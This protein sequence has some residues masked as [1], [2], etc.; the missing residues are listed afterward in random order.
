MTAPVN[1]SPAPYPSPDLPRWHA[2]LKP[3]ATWVKELAEVG[4]SSYESI[5][6]D[7][8]QGNGDSY[9]RIIVNCGGFGVADCAK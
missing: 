3:C 8:A 6:E 4:R 9:G 2:L 7:D 5:R 1:E